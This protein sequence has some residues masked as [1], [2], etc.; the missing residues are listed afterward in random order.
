MDGPLQEQSTKTTKNPDQTQNFPSNH[1]F[2]QNQ[3]RDSCP[4][5]PTTNYK[6]TNLYFNYK[7]FLS[8]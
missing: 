4:P 2:G 1:N 7:F 5:D 6:S 3:V 8:I